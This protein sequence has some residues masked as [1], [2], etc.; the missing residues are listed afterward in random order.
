[1]ATES[2]APWR[3]VGLDR[4]EQHRLKRYAVLRAASR[5]FAARGYFQTSLADIA[6]EFN[7]NKATLYH[8]F[9]SKEEILFEIHAHAIASIIDDE[10]AAE[11][12]A[13]NGRE[14]LIAFIGRYV[15]ML[16]DDFGACLVLTDLKPLEKESYDQ[17][18]AGRRHID[19]LLRTILREGIEDGSLAPMDPKT[20][21][22]FIF[23]ALNWICHW[24]HT[25][26]EI[27][28][29]ELKRR[30]TEFALRAVEKRP[31]E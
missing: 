10:P 29:D 6:K 22:S 27:T 30:A 8:Y 11:V 7:L 21:A 25:E 17:C 14:R 23:G 24:Y 31:G 3:N 2:N 5:A 19:N 28:P 16:I 12:N 18:V 15:D 4:S 20:T 26:G 1:M 13:A 9:K